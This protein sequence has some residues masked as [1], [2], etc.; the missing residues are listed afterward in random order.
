M[1]TEKLP[2]SN[3]EVTSLVMV[4]VIAGLAG[5]ARVLYGKDELRWRWTVASCLVS[6][7]TAIMIYGVLVR[8]FGEIGGHSSAA[9]GAAVGLFTDDVLKRSREF[10]R[11][12]SIT[13]T[14]PTVG[15][16]PSTP[17]PTKR[18]VEGR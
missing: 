13:G 15:E 10:I 11:S 3:Q 6:M 9:I 5:L 4:A 14:K 12:V 8:Q 17:P 18:D 2:S 1:G 7:L 16:M